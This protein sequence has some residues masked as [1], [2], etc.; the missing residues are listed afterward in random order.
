MKASIDKDGSNRIELSTERI[1]QIVYEVASGKRVDP[2]D[3]DQEAI[4]RAQT[5][6]WQDSL[7]SGTVVDCPE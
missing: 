3:T 1:R 7:P 5:A 2:N 6:K 4:F